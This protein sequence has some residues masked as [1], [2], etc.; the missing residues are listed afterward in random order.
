MPYQSEQSSAKVS[1]RFVL[2]QG[3]VC[4]GGA[5]T[6]L[7]AVANSAK[8]DPLPQKAV[9]YQTTPKGDRRCD[10]CSLF[11]APKACKNVAGEISPEGWC[12]LWRKI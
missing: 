2:L 10:G 8:A 9:Q 7:A 6:V 3:A 12:I 5:A 11:V 4:A 1:R